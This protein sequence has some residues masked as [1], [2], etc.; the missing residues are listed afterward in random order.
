MN[1]LLL[2]S[3]VNLPLPDSVYYIQIQEFN[4]DNFYQL[5]QSLNDLP[6]YQSIKGLILD[7]RDNPGGEIDLAVQSAQLWIPEDSLIYEKIDA[8]G[9]HSYFVKSERT[10]P[11]FRN[12]PTVILVNRQTASAAELLALSLKLNKKAVVIGE[13]TFGKGLIVLTHGNSWLP[14]G[15]WRI[16]G[17][18]IQG[19]GIKPTIFSKKPL[20]RAIKYFERRTK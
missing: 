4:S 17:I 5:I 13:K 7:L 19:K 15:Y 12:I 14:I 2:I 9:R 10:N 1:I 20:E 16:K 6:N 3:T 18:C 11:P 8:C